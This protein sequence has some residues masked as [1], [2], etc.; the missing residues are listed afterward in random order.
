[1]DLVKAR[2]NLRVKGGTQMADIEAGRLFLV[3]VHTSQS[4]GGRSSNM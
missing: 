1:M 3:R 4:Q 2:I